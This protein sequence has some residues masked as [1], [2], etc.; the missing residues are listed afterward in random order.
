MAR[1][2]ASVEGRS[3]KA[4]TKVGS[5]KSGMTAHVRGWDL[6]CEV[7]LSVDETTGKDVMKVYK[8][9]GSRGSVAKELIG[10]FTDED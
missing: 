3:A 2:F 7:L 5:E 10:E 9:G 8:T 4:V 6:G 1:F